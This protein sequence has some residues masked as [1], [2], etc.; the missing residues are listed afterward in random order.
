MSSEIIPLFADALYLTNINRKFTTEELATVD[1]ISKDLRKN[2][3]NW[4]SANKNILDSNFSDIRNFIQEH[5]NNY[6]KDIVSPEE[7]IDVYITQSWINV[8][9]PKESHHQHTH[10]NSFISG[11]FY[12]SVEHLVDSIIFSKKHD[13]EFLFPTKSPNQF[14]SSNYFLKLTNGDLVIFPSNLPHH[15]ENTISEAPR[16][17]LSF[18]T[19]IKGQIGNNED[20]TGL[21][22]K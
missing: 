17:S 3:G 1:L 21:Y 14:N 18:N 6:V 8:T 9:K 4:T 12:F 7:S 22:L 11:V 13:R 10:P 16:I 20:S 5:I 15:V 2:K 19:F